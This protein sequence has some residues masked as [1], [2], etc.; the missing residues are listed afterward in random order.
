[1]AVGD[2]VEKKF[3]GPTTLGASSAALGSAVASGYEQVVKQ[4]VICN[5]S[6]ID[7]LVYLAI[8][9][10]ATAGNRFISALPIAA[11]DLMVFDTG[12]VLS[13]GDQF[14]GYSDYASAVNVMAVGWEKQIA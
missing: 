6:G 12:I 13:A 9:S 4:I 2:R 10:A 7:A 11:N 3:F 5:T 8:G 1:M 14:Y